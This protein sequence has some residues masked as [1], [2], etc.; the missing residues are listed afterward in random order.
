V[1]IGNM[2]FVSGPV[3]APVRELVQVNAE[4][5]SGVRV[6]VADDAAPFRALLTD[7]LAAAPAM[8]CVEAVDSGEAAIDAV[9]RLSP[10][11]VV[12]D[13]RMPGMGGIAAAREITARHPAIVVVLVSLEAPEAAALKASGAAAF[14]KKG[15]L[16]PR[17]LA[18]VWAAH[19]PGRA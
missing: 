7:L 5:P 19:Q 18:E 16:S 2:T 6:L 1:N 3:F 9:D 11:M 15:E 8:T 17:A 12:I 10:H 13:K 14:L 4:E